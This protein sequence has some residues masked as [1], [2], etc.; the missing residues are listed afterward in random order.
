MSRV[1]NETRTET[2]IVQR[3]G[4]IVSRSSTLCGVYDQPLT[5]SN[6]VQLF[7]SLSTQRRRPSPVLKPLA[8]PPLALR[9]HEFRNRE[10]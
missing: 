4:T 8:I 6:Y 2:Q 10:G 9:R 3:R 1:R 7:H 5:P